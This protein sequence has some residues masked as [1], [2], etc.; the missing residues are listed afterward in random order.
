MRLINIEIPLPSI[1]IFDIALN[2]DVGNSALLFERYGS[3]SE[4]AG[5]A[6]L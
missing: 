1:V 4:R 6:N 2:Q 3:A 5:V